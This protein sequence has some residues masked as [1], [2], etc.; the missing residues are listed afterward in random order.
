MFNAFN[1]KLI[2]DPRAILKPVLGYEMCLVQRQSLTETKYKTR[3]AAIGR[4]LG[5]Q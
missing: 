4:K 5:F 1:R 3:N 2:H